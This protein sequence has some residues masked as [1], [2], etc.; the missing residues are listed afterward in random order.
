M[1]DA[2]AGRDTES[3][4]GEGDGGTVRSGPGRR[5]ELV[6]P[7]GPDDGRNTRIGLALLASLVIGF[8]PLREAALGS[9]SFPQA[10]GRYLVCLAACVVAM[11][12]L[13]RL[14]DGAPEPEDDSGPQD[15]ELVPPTST[16]D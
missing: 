12:V 13:G 9:G 4:Q 15:G 5:L 14:L 7:A 3:G 11:L 6:E 1:A 2:A 8:G 16:P 10:L